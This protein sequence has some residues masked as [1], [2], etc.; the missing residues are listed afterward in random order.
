MDYKEFYEEV[1]T[2]DTLSKELIAT[3]LD[4]LEYGHLSFVNWSVDILSIIKT[5]IDRGDKITDA[6]SGITYNV[7]T[8]HDFVKKNFPSYVEIGVY[9]K[10]QQKTYFQLV[11]CKEGYSLI[12]VEDGKQKIYEWISSLSEKFSLCYLIATGIVYIKN[13]KT[14]TYSIFISSNGNYCRYDKEKGKI[15]EIC[16]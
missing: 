16:K 13:M 8:F 1:T 10:K 15:I 6:V 11:P 3:L 2:S 5:R 7:K 14:G 12:I 4:T 9:S